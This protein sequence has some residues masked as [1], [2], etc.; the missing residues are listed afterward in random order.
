MERGSMR[1]ATWALNLPATIQLKRTSSKCRASGA[2]FIRLM[3]RIM[4][5]RN[6]RPIAEAAIM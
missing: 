1:K 6:E 4:V 3:K 5:V 2:T